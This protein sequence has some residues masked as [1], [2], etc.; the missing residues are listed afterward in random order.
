MFCRY[1]FWQATSAADFVCGR[2]IVLRGAYVAL[3]P[4][5]VTIVLLKHYA[6]RT[7]GQ[8]PSPG[9]TSV[10]AFYG[11]DQYHTAACS[12]VSRDR[13]LRYHELFVDGKGTFA[14]C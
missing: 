8:I 13:F 12:S 4:R 1:M 7:A 6:H 9:L 10:H 2:S 5:K 11:V 3:T 14:D